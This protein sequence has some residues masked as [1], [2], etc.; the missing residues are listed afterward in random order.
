MS[1][2][3]LGYAPEEMIGHNAIDFIHPDDLESTRHEM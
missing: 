2:T 3:I 1:S